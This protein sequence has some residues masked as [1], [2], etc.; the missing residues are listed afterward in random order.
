MTM[1]GFDDI[2]DAF[3]AEPPPPEDTDG[4]TDYQYASVYDWVYEWLAPATSFK[5]SD[6]G[7]GRVFCKKWFLHPP[8][9]VR[10]DSLW[11]A[12]EKAARSGDDAAMDSWYTYS[13]DAA[14]RA[15]TDPEGPMRNC[16]PKNHR[17]T[18]HLIV[19]RAPA[20]HIALAAAPGSLL[21]AVT[22][23]TDPHTN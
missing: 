12:W 17:D 21:Q 23:P 20:D 1:D 15:L 10:L 18:P 22:P 3:T 19:D 8:V 7:R 5:V 4:G 14:I 13:Y 11:R 9:V 2:D 6:G 16:G